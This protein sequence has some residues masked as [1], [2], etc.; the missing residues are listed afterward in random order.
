MERWWSRRPPAIASYKKK[1][2]ERSAGFFSRH[3]DDHW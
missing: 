1:P 2:A 3:C